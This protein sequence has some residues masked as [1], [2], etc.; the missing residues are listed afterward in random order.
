MICAREA[1][2]LQKAAAELRALAGAGQSVLALPADVARTSD[3]DALVE[4]AFS[5][6][7]RLDILVNNAAIAGP[8]GALE[9]ND[10][11][12]WIHTI[13]VNLLGPVSLSR[14]VLPHF[15]RARRG[16]IIQLSGGGAA[17]PVS[18]RS[19]YAVSKAAVVR[20]VE[21]LA[22]ETR[23][24]H[25]DVNAI[26]PGVLNTRM[27][28]D[29]L[30]AGPEILGAAAHEGILTQQRDGGM[31][32]AKGADL[33]VFLGSSASDGISGKLISAVWDPWEELPNH[34]ADLNGTD[35]YALRRILP[36]DR[37]MTWGDRD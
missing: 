25:I 5:E 13:E 36:K 21:T 6:F 22:E 3:V 31:P 17:N 23:Q 18:N 20:F 35:V 1:L 9:S 27:L 8:I 33:A 19:A 7:G 14:A 37:G 11:R 15:K 29:I 16:K 24:Y 34:L 12:E 26:A 10:W 32:L 4:A 28:R 2:P 30:A